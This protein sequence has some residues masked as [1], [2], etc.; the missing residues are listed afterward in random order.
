MDFDDPDG[1]AAWKKARELF[2][3]YYEDFFEGDQPIVEKVD[4][5]YETY[6][7][8]VLKMNPDGESKGVI[9]AHGGFDSSYEEFSHR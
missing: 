8:P 9:V 7:L 5:P 4:V 2:F 6:T 1:L 3:Q